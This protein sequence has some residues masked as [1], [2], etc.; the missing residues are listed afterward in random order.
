[1]SYENNKLNNKN[2]TGFTLIEIVVST[3][4]FAIL[5]ISVGLIFKQSLE[6]QRRAL[7]SQNIQESMRY[8]LE[9][10]SKEMRNAERM[11]GAGFAPAPADCT[12]GGTGTGDN[13][14]V[15]SAID[16]DGD[17]VGG[18]SGIG[19][20][21]RLAFRNKDDSCVVYELGGI[22][23]HQVMITR[24]DGAGAITGPITPSSIIV[25]DLKFTVLD[26]HAD[27]KI[28]PSVNMIAEA[29]IG[30][31]MALPLRFQTTISSR[32]YLDN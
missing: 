24:D 17:P 14:N 31:A 18:G 4:I 32:Y 29:S 5:M 11:N 30:N 26:D 8:A 15:F 20:G 13:D 22:G 3:T 28:Q 1:M 12:T 21:D 19:E 9:V 2:H 27:N 23:N 6:G 10:M 25:R 7:A 16:A